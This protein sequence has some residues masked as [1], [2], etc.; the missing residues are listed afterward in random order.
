[1]AMNVKLA[2]SDE[3]VLGKGI[4]YVYGK[5]KIK[6]SSNIFACLQIGKSNPTNLDLFMSM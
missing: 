4:Q 3:V 6:K 1:M 5:E 2:G